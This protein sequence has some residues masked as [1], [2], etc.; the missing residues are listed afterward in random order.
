MELSPSGGAANSAA[1]QEF[2]SILWNPRVHY[3]VHKDPPLVPILSQI[4]PIHTIPPYLS[5]IH[6]NII[7]LSTPWSSLWSLYFVS[8]RQA[9][10]LNNI[11]EEGIVHH[12]DN[13]AA[14]ETVFSPERNAALSATDTI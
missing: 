7:H 13:D 4:Y 8:G 11:T 3:R 2:P 14:I 5:K 12:S 1:T 6:S 10:H 9:L